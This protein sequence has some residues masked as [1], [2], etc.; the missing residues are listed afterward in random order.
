MVKHAIVEEIEDLVHEF[1][2][3]YL[4]VADQ[5]NEHIHARYAVI[6]R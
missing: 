3:L 5:A 6:P 1:E 4:N 2:D